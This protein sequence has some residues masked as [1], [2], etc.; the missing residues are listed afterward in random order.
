MAAHG[1]ERRLQQAD[2]VDQREHRADGHGPGAER[3][4][5][6]A[7]RPGQRQDE[8]QR[9]GRANDG[10]EG[11]GASG[12]PRVGV[13]QGV[14]AGHH[15]GRAA[16][17]DDVLGAGDMFFQKAEQFGDGAADAGE[18]RHHAFLDDAQQRHHDDGIAQRQQP[19][20]PVLQKYQND[21][22]RHQQAVADEA[23]DDLREVLGQLADVA[24]DALDQLAGCAQFVEAHVQP[25]D[26]GRQIGAQGVGRGPTKVFGQIDGDEKQRLLGQHGGEEQPGNDVETIRR[27]VS[28]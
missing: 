9:A 28:S 17:G 2:V 8:Q 13:Q 11:V 7:H 23:D 27:I 10:A 16:V 20:A 22:A 25:Q 4:G 3:Q 15:V 21:D 18:E 6:Q 1:V 24:V 19:D 12:Q 5:G 26:V 14:E